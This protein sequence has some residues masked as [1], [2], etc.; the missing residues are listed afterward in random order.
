[1]VRIFL[2]IL[3]GDG[4]FA[5][6][7]YG[8]SIAQCCGKPSDIFKLWA[9]EATRCAPWPKTIDTLTFFIWIFAMLSPS[10]L[11]SFVE[12]MNPQQQ[13]ELEAVLRPGN[14][15]HT[16]FLAA[17]ESL[18]TSAAAKA[19]VLQQ[20]NVTFD[21][22][23]DRI[24]AVKNGGSTARLRVDVVG[25]RGWQNCP[26]TNCKATGS[27]DIYITQVAAGKKL[28]IPSLMPHL[29][30][31]HHFLEGEVPYGLDPQE[32]IEVLDLKNHPTP[33]AGSQTKPTGASEKKPTTGAPKWANKWGNYRG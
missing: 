12:D 3:P 2:G 1:L 31:D 19:R 24:E 20:N 27:E 15:S 9:V 5:K 22:L 18:A 7:V 14:D 29:I 11:P 6:A 16:G 8:H 33:E 32:A 13:A 25:Y 17:D 23:A 28:T 10:R 21:A 4:P 26:F 30:R